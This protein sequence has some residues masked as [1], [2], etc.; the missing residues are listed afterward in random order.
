MSL[1]PFTRF[2]VNV[3]HIS[4]Q[5]KARALVFEIAI[6]GPILSI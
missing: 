3:F 4:E 1:T 2:T 6:N 5:P